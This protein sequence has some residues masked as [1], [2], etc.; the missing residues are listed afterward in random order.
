MGHSTIKTAK[1]FDHMYPKE[2][3]P[4]AG[5]TAEELKIKGFTEKDGD[6]RHPKFPKE[7][8]IEEYEGKWIFMWDDSIDECVGDGP[9]ELRLVT[10]MYQ[11]DNM[12][13]GFTDRWLGYV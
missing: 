12:F 1:K 13:H 3:E 7:L 8:F 9:R 6:W 11:I 4:W 2:G 10:Y 5:I